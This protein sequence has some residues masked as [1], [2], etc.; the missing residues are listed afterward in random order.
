MA[1]ALKAGTQVAPEQYDSAT[2]SFVDVVEFTDLCSASTPLQI[3][4]LLNELFSA[5]DALIEQHD[6]YKVRK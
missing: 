3:I 2:I 4:D 1:N 6:V 5:F